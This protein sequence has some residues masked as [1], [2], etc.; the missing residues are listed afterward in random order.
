MQMKMKLMI[1]K[2]YSKIILI[3]N[4]CINKKKR[5]KKNLKI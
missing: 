2:I 4:N 3:I 1:N 5:K